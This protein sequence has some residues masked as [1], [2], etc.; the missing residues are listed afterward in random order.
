MSS[1]LGSATGAG[2][3]AVTV[4]HSSILANGMRLEAALFV[5]DAIDV[6]GSITALGSDV[7]I[8]GVPCY[9]LNKV[10]VLCNLMD[11]F[12]CGRGVNLQLLTC[13]E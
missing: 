7:F 2:S 3:T 1:Y 11:A 5:G 4:R 6:H 8:Q 12:A 13:S 9:T 10:I